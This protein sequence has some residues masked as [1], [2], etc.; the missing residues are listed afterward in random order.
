MLRVHK[1]RAVVQSRAPWRTVLVYLGC[2][3]T[4][5][6][7]VTIMPRFHRR[8]CRSIRPLNKLPQRRP[9][10]ILIPIAPSAPPS[11]RSNQSDPRILWDCAVQLHSQRPKADVDHLFHLV[12]LPFL[13]RATGRLQIA[14]SL[15]VVQ[16]IPSAC[17]YRTNLPDFFGR[18][19]W[20]CSGISPTPTL[21]S[22]KLHRL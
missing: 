13:H 19:P 11:P 18:I 15:F 9:K 16:L 12:Y 14:S 4:R 2:K 21:R 22:S 3:H 17:L 5:R 6:I 20:T 7:G 10:V 8:L 1:I